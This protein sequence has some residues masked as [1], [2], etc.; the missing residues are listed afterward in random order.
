MK[1]SVFIHCALLN[2][3]DWRVSFFI[4]KMIQTGLYNVEYIIL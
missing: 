4:E 2:R 3:C 1:K